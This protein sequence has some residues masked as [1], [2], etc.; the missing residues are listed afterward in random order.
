MSLMM[1]VWAKPSHQ[2]DGLFGEHSKFQSLN[3]GLHVGQECV[4]C[5]ES[6]SIVIGTI[7]L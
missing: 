5:L 1:P 6:V 7:T 3:N 4:V 2:L